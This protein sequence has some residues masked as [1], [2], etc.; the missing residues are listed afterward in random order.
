MSLG[1]LRTTLLAGLDNVDMLR[2]AKGLD[3]HRRYLEFRL[4]CGKVEE[5]WEVLTL[6]QISSCAR[7]AKAMRDIAHVMHKQDGTCGS[8]PRPRES[9]APQDR[10]DVRRA[11]A[12]LDYLGASM[13]PRGEEV[14][15]DEQGSF[16]ARSLAREVGDII[17]DL[18]PLDGC[19]PVDSQRRHVAGVIFRFET[20]S[21]VP[22][23]RMVQRA[24]GPDTPEFVVWDVCQALA[25]EVLGGLRA[26]Q[27]PAKE[28]ADA[29]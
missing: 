5:R 14:F 13:R 10:A 3:L 18:L 16:T 23:G 21:G 11:T 26:D 6:A 4:A 28:M 19:D 1:K 17:R 29:R 15:S 12:R 2:S 24:L 7:V 27:H 20:P 8:A 22:L 9:E 25:E